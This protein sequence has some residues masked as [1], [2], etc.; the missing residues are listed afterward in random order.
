MMS[1][2]TVL[3]T[4]ATGKQGGNVAHQLLAKG[5][6]VRA[7]TRRPDSAA[8][9]QLQELGAELAIGNLEDRAALEKA[10]QGVE[11]V[12]SMSTAFESDAETEIR[13]GKTVAD[14]VKAVGVPHLVYSSVAD[15][16]RSTGVPHFD[17]KWEVEQYIRSLL[18]PHSIVA[19][20]GFMENTIAQWAIE[21]LK[22]GKYSPGTKPSKSPMIQIAAE[23]IASFAVL[24]LE[25]RDRF[26][27]LRVKIAA[28]ERP[29]YECAE[30]L[31]RVTGK[32]IEYV[33]IPRE[34]AQQQSEDFQI[35]WRW[36]EQVGTQIDIPALHQEYPEMRWHS[37]DEWAK[38][39]DWSF[40]NSQVAT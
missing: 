1:N 15:G 2:L 12:F 34:F 23:D 17:S 31:S 4:G 11:A 18:I 26:C 25:H 16:D 39:Q 8:A 13:Q 7:L 32:K 30:I 10:M 3:V 9:R 19:P 21:G 6:K 28:D 35:M 29:G 24:M 22:Q 5:H 20:A 38:K 27:G 37:F 36:D 40:L 14:A 33:P